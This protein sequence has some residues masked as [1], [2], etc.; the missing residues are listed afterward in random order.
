[1]VAERGAEDW[2]SEIQRFPRLFQGHESIPGLTWPTTPFADRLTVY[3]GKRRFDLMKPGRAHTAGD[4]AVH[5]PDES[6]MF[7]GDILE[8]HS[9]C[10]CGDGHFADWS[11]TPEAIRA[12]DLAA[13]A[14]GRSCAE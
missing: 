3:H 11:P 12:F 8:A 6:V 5:V 1:M 13:I 10:Y 2:A 9:A 7:T 4:I 14:P